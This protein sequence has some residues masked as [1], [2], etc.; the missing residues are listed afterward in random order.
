MKDAE[1]TFLVATDV[2]SSIYESIYITSR[3][4]QTTVKVCYKA[5]Q[6]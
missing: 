1:N 3:A 2:V 6:Y 5:L 4:M